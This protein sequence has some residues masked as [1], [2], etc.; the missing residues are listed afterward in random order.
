MSEAALT[1]EFQY[2]SARHQSE[3]AVAGMWLF[4]ATE[5]LFFG[6]LFL[7]WIYARHWTQAGFDAGAQQTDLTIGTINT[8]IL[9]ASSFVYSLGAAFMEFGNTRRLIQCCVF[10]AGLGVVFLILKFGI[11]WHE[12]FHKHLFPGPGFAIEGALGGGARIFFVF[13]FVSTALHGL[14]MIVGLCLVGWIIARARLGEFSSSYNTPVIVVGLYWSFVDMV[15]IM[16][17]PLIYLV[18]RGT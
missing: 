6:A 12:D 11:E 13:Y 8:A 16:L 3:T 5:V 10:A 9:I 18:G 4:L 2:S 14:H 17:Y 7:S 15:W 1:H